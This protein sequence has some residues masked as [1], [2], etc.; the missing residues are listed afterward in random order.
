LE[1][2]TQKVMKIQNLFF[3]ATKRM[4]FFELGS[5]KF[6]NNKMLG[7]LKTLSPEEQIEFDCDIN[8]IHWP[9]YLMNYATGL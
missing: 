8:N 4:E 1:K 9:T 3:D 5:W 6:V 7:L 2:D